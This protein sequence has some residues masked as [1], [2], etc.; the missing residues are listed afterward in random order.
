[1]EFEHRHEERSRCS[2]DRALAM[3]ICAGGFKKS[4]HPWQ[5]VSGACNH[6]EHEG[7]LKAPKRISLRKFFKMIASGAPLAN[8]DQ[9]GAYSEMDELASSLT[10][11][12]MRTRDISRS[13]STVLYS[14][15]A[16]NPSDASPPR[17][18]NSRLDQE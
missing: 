7:A 10:F 11:P 9:T 13:Y 1:M 3:A 18:S 12:K 6:P 4:Q 15:T 14:I 8:P 5:V 2:S 17:I 16:P